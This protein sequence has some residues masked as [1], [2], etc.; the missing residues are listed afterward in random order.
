MSGPQDGLQILLKLPESG[1]ETQWTI[2]RS[3]DCDI[4]LSYDPQVSR[5]HARLICLSNNETVAD[6]MAAHHTGSLRFRLADVGSRN[7]TLFQDRRLRNESA[8]LKPGELFRVGRTWL[9]IDP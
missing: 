2:G 4:I 8:D 3:E 9:R 6:G 5:R 7:G 1:G